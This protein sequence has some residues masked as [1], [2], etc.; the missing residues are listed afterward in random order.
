ML[1]HFFEHHGF[2]ETE[3]HLHADNCSGQNKNRYMM[4]YLLWRVLTGLHKEVMISFLPVGHTKFAPDWCFGL[5]KQSFRRTKVDTLDD[6]ANS[7]SR[8]SFVNVPQL[9]GTLDGTCLVKMFNWSDFFEQHMVKTAL[10]GIK[11]M[12]HFRFEAKSPGMVFVKNSSTD[13]E[14]KIKLVK[15]TSWSPSSSDLPEKIV[16]PGLPLE[17]QWYL[18]EKIREFCSEEAKNIVCP[19]PSQSLPG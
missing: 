9:V 4:Q 5:A 2:G 15:H 13:S 19:K 11:Q 1:H 17:R 12:H 3:V 8:S 16:P 7:V 6:I 18:Y 10:T 14:K